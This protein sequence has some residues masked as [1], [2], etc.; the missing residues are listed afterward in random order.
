MKKL[1]SAV[2][3]V[4]YLGSFHA[5]KYKNNHRAELVAV[6]DLYKDQADKVA[7]ELQ[8]KSYY[9]PKDLIGLVDA[10][11]IATTTRSHYDVA[12]FFLENGVHVNVEK[13]I[14][15]SLEDGEKLVTLAKA[16]GLKLAV[17]QIER[18]NPV[19]EYLKFHVK[20]PKFIELR[21]LGP[22]KGRGADVSVLHDLM[23]H[24]LDILFAFGV[25]EL[26][27]FKISGRS[28]LSRTP[29]WASAW[30]K[31]S[32]GVEATVVSSRVNPQAERNIKIF[33]E[34]VVWHGNFSNF[35]VEK[36][37]LSEGAEVPMGVDKQTLS[38]VD[39][40]QVETDRFIEAILDD[41]QCAVSGEEGLKNLKVVETLLAAIR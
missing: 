23:I 36:V 41:K 27:D 14:T 1:R 12:A 39:A 40:L 17:G 38:R 7:R 21:R 26:V 6:C 22:F 20:T 11:T 35:E 4:G 32:S 5:Q 2:V 16:K 29:D 33:E 9:Q 15:S 25:G 28:Y 37:Y 8:V 34:N 31:F 10:V 19:F 24:D 3:G 18:F 30:L 13:P